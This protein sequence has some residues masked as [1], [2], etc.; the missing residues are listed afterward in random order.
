MSSLGLTVYGPEVAKSGLTAA[1]DDF[2]RRKTELEIEERS[3]AVH[4]RTSIEAFY[5]LTGSTGG[6][7]WPLVLDLFDMRPVCATLWIGDSALSSLQYLKGKTQ[8]AQAAKGTI[9]SRFYCDNPVTNLVHVSDSESLMDE[10]LRI[11]RAHSTG[12]GDT[13]WRALNSGRI[14][15]SSFR[16]LLTSLG[17]TQ[18]PQS[19][20]CNSGDD[21][22]ANARAAFEQ[23]EALAVSCGMLETV[24]GFL[25]GDFASLEY[26]LNRVGGLSAWDRL[27]LEAG[28]FA[29]PYWNSLINDSPALLTG[30]GA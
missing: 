3:F 16:V 30:E 29:M 10:E 15:H 27:L 2:I 4:S 8:P 9:R 11:L 20:I 7:H 19:D 25:A 24:Q 21:A 23:A 18:A 6:K 12:T 5:S 22:V 28:L 26:L 17:N 13:S 1:L 14:S